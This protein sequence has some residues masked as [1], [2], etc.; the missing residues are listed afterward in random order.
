[1]CLRK[2]RE[3][4]NEKFAQA[5]EYLISTP[6]SYRLSPLEHMFEVVEKETGLSQR[7][8]RD[9]ITTN[10]ALSEPHL[11]VAQEQYDN[12]LRIMRYIAYCY[13][14]EQILEDGSKVRTKYYKYAPLIDRRFFKSITASDR[15][16]ELR[17]NTSLRSFFVGFLEDSAVCETFRP[18]NPTEECVAAG[19]QFREKI[20]SGTIRV[21]E[22]KLKLWLGDGPLYRP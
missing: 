8:L 17:I 15:F 19:K 13:N 9:T 2:L 11:R 20:K 5:F 12:F 4:S 1:M 10:K 16:E 14:S 18:G 21:V 6:K 3:N 22:R 7:S